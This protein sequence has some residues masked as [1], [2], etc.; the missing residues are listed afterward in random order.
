MAGG[1]RKK[2]KKVEEDG[3]RHLTCMCSSVAR[4]QLAELTWKAEFQKI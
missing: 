2:K 3:P 1:G 4:N